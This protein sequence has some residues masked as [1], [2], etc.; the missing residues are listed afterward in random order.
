MPN[1]VKL[2][3]T[4]KTLAGMW[5]ELSPKVRERY[6]RVATE[7]KARYK[8][9]LQH[10]SGP[11]RVPN[12]RQKKPA[13]APKRAMSAFLSFSQEK[14]HLVRQE[15]PN[16]KNTD[17]SG[18]LATLWKNASEEEK[19]PHIN[20]EQRDREKYHAEMERWRKDEAEKAREHERIRSQLQQDEANTDFFNSMLC[21]GEIPRVDE[22]GP[23][24]WDHMVNSQW[25]HEGNIVNPYSSSRSESIRTNS[26]WYRRPHQY[27]YNSFVDQPTPVSSGNYGGP[28]LPIDPQTYGPYRHQ[29]GTS[30]PPPSTA[31]SSSSNTS[32]QT[33]DQQ[34]F[35]A[36]RPKKSRYNKGDKNTLDVSRTQ[37]Q[38]S[39]VN[40]VQDPSYYSMITT[41]AISAYS[42]VNSDGAG[43]VGNNRHYSNQLQPGGIHQH[44]NNL[45]LM[46]PQR[47]QLL[48]Y[49]DYRAMQ[50]HATGRPIK[51]ANP[52]STPYD[53]MHPNTSTNNDQYSQHS[54]NIP[55]SF[56]QK[57]V[58]YKEHSLQ[59][60]IHNNTT[61]RS[62]YP[63]LA[64][65]MPESSF[66]IQD[67]MQ[68][69]AHNHMLYNGMIGYVSDTDSGSSNNRTDTEKTTN[70]HTSVNEYLTST[71]LDDT[72]NLGNTISG[73]INR[74]EEG[75]SALKSLDAVSKAGMFG[76]YLP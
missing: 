28:P 56:F 69:G 17:I 23:C 2:T 54:S 27:P 26:E 61:N 41:P 45:D 46:H 47:Q 55:Q 51:N 73:N 22:E 9:E 66:H 44:G 29:L 38:T 63:S 58:F 25:L 71:I 24:A 18:I 34:V 68:N 76:N 4:I 20:R 15:N 14:R 59:A 75:Q 5:K 43:T 42:R 74:S 35:E 62:V 32:K 16:L 11:M 64:L 49:D 8:R 12:R 31:S 36:P 30:I 57:D 70:V 21:V 67:S 13:G 39:Q 60:A 52:A 65:Q 48:Y 1:D 50:W 37:L 40:S 6:E 10:Y 19:A 7:D 72:T 53:R 3:D 33:L